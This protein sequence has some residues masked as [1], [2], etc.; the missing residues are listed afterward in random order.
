MIRRRKLDGR[1]ACSTALETDRHCGRPWRAPGSAPPALQSRRG[2]PAVFEP[3]P[4]SSL[5][6]HAHCD[7][8]AECPR[9]KL[10]G[11]LAAAVEEEV[12]LNQHG[13]S[14]SWTGQAGIKIHR[15]M[16]QITDERSREPFL[17]KSYFCEVRTSPLPTRL[18]RR[19]QVQPGR[20]GNQQ[21]GAHSHR[22]VEPAPC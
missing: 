2:D 15:T 16:S 11:L 13:A 21:V 14:H 12:G 22:I 6:M 20:G 8:C 7:L 1:F 5:T 3:C 4:V 10:Q 18:P 19:S 17:S 9:V